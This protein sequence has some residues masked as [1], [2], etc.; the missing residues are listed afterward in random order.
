MDLINYRIF[1]V[2]NVFFNLTHCGLLKFNLNNL[3]NLT[4]LV[5]ILMIEIYIFVV[6]FPVNSNENKLNKS[7]FFSLEAT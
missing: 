5:C 2:K 1:S 3:I 4:F 6:F 7:I